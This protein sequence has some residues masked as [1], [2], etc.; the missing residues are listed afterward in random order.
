MAI[1]V[2][3]LERISRLSQLLHAFIEAD[4]GAFH[5]LLFL[6]KNAF[7]PSRK[8]LGCGD[9]LSGKR[10][11]EL[12]FSLFGLE[13]F[14]GLDVGL[15]LG[16]WPAA[17]S[18]RGLDELKLSLDDPLSVNFVFSGLGSEADWSVELKGIV[19]VELAAELIL[20]IHN[21]L[22]FSVRSSTGSS[23][24]WSNAWGN[25]GSGSRSFCKGNGGMGCKDIEPNR[26]LPA[27]FCESGNASSKS[28]HVRRG[29]QRTRSGRE[30]EREREAC[31][32]GKRGVRRSGKEP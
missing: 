22:W 28:L 17:L 12:G 8:G 6:Q 2:S 27:E 23:S 26:L 20:R 1:Q 14:A 10:G 25:A 31:S 7:K 13:L 11:L 18:G 15:L 19:A 3:K 21:G 24:A 4:G 29:E 5:V 30:R 9:A 16:D 32:S